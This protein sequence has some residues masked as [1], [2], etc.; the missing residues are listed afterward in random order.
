MITRNGIEY[1]NLVEQVQKNKEDIAKHYDIE[2]TLSDWGIKVIGRLDTWEEPTGSFTFGDAYAVGPEGGPFDFYIWTRRS[3]VGDEGYW[4]N[5]GP[6]SIVGPQGPQGEP[7]PQGATGKSGK[8]FSGPSV[9]TG[10]VNEGDMWLKLNNDGST[11]GFV[12]TYRNSNWALTTSIKG[13]QGIQGTQGPT[14]PRGLTGPAGPQGER[15]APAPIINILGMLESDDQLPDPSTV[16]ANSGY[17]ITEEGNNY[18][19]IIINGVWT[20]SGRW[21]GGT[22]VYAENEFQTVF[23]A[24]TKVD[25]VINATTNNQLYGKTITG[26]QTMFDVQAVGANLTP[27]ANIIPRYNS[28][29]KLTT[30]SPSTKYEC[31]NKQYVDNAIANAHSNT[32]IYHMG[33]FGVKTEDI[34]SLPT[35]D[36]P[37]APFGDYGELQLKCDLMYHDGSHYVNVPVPC[38]IQFSMISPPDM[39]GNAQYYWTVYEALLNS[40][41]V[42]GYCGAISTTQALESAYFQIPNDQYYNEVYITI[43]CPH[44]T[45]W[46]FPGY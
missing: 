28:S 22:S 42:S 15:G 35:Y 4:L 12:Y 38:Y 26:A 7:G 1:R 23:N 3:G 33:V 31:A 19:F 36:I 32:E 21:G 18:L 41:M 2:K 44:D 11:D 29:G 8:W 16:E 30:Y 24:D 20:N 27:S 43:H 40:S 45:A 25:K 6:I 9:P 13:P 5:Y 14:G 37:I 39:D 10:E 34:A 17:L 46:Y